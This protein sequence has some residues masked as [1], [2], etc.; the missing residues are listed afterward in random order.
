MQLCLPIYYIYYS[1]LYVK[2]LVHVALR[3]FFLFFHFIHPLKI[4]SFGVLVPFSC[5]LL[6]VDKL[7]FHRSLEMFLHCFPPLSSRTK[8]SHNLMRR[9]T[10]RLM[11]RWVRRPTPPWSRTVLCHLM[12][13]ATPC[14]EGRGGAHP[15]G[16]ARRRRRMNTPPPATPAHTGTCT[17][18]TSATL[19][20]PTAPTGTN[21]RTGCCDTKLS[22]VTTRGTAGSAA[23]PG[24]ETPTELRP[25]P[26]DQPPLHVPTAS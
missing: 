13:P 5:V 24:P 16:V 22:K 10:W 21:H 12:R 2:K 6:S 15:P 8:T 20:T 11:R 17:H 4:T 3:I 14:L 19:A 25:P 1:L 18:L 7:I 9:L 26:P 23:A